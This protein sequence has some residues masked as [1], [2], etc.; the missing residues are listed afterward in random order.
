MCPTSFWKHLHLVHSKVI[1]WKARRSLEARNPKANIHLIPLTI[2]ISFTVIN[3][4]LD[5]TIKQSNVNEPNSLKRKTVNIVVKSWSFSE[6]LTN[7]QNY[8]IHYTAIRTLLSISSFLLTIFH[9]TF[10]MNLPK[11][12][13]IEVSV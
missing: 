5:I 8:E 11:D 9:L 6:Q 3:T 4:N 7:H 13:T 1:R 12:L 2:L 10:C